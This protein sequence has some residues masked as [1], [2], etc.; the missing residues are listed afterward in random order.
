M[1]N[2]TEKESKGRFQLFIQRFG[3]PVILG[4]KEHAKIKTLRN[5]VAFLSIFVIVSAGLTIL[6]E[7]I[8][9]DT[10]IPGQEETWAASVASYWGGII[11]GILS[12]A[13]AFIGVFWTIRYYKESDVKRERASIQPF[14]RVDI[15]TNVHMERF[16]GFALGEQPEDK[17][18]QHKINL[19]IRNIGNGF[20]NILVI[21]TGFNQGGFEFNRVLSVTE[22]VQL[23]L[24]YNVDRIEEGLPFEIQYIDSMT[25]EYLQRYLLVKKHGTT[26][27]ECGYPQLLG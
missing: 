3:K 21:K 5:A 6:I 10:I 17:N 22:S 25:N 11:G 7:R 20:A 15:D 4:E 2:K 16:I 1:M 26:N 27:I 12:G 18:K 9:R 13:L 23:A 14:L 24:F 8:I 19:C